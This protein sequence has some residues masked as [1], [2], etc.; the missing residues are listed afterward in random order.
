MVKD[1]KL[2]A[3]AAEYSL[4]IQQTIGLGVVLKTELVIELLQVAKDGL[5]SRMDRASTTQP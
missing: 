4:G 2:K 5:S 3:I 1:E